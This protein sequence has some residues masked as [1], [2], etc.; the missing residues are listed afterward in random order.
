MGRKLEKIHF[1]RANLPWG[2]VRVK[3]MPLNGL[4]AGFRGLICA[5]R[6]M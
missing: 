1:G 4:K 2:G 3:A 5:R 6:I